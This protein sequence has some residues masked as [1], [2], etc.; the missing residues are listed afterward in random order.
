MIA[1]HY[2]RYKR[3]N[4]LMDYDDLIIYLRELLSKEP[5]I[6]KMISKRYRYIL[7]DEYQDTNSIQADIL[8]W[9]GSQSRNIMVVGD[10][11]Q[12]IYAFRGANYNN[13]FE[14][15]EIF[16]D[17]KIIKLEENYRSTQPILTFTNAIME[18][19]TKGYTKCLFTRKKDGVRPKIID[20]GT[21]PRQA[22]AVCRK[23]LELFDRG[24][25]LK[26]MAVLF[27]ASYHSFELE[28]ELTRNGIPYV[29]YGG[30][31]FME[32][33][34]I[35]DL[36]SHLRVVVNPRDQ[37]SWNRILR[38]VPGIGPVKARAIFEWL[39]KEGKLPGELADWPGM[40]KSEKGLKRLSSLLKRL[41]AP[42]ISPEK[43]VE[44][45]LKYYRPI[46]EERFDDYPKREKDLDQ[47]TIMAG[48]YK[49]LKNFI[50]DIVLE[51][52]TSSSEIVP[53]DKDEVL[54]LSTVHSAKGL[55]WRV[56]FIIWA[57]DGYFP[58]SRAFKDDEDM[59]EERRLMYVATT[60]AKELL[61]I[62][63]PGNEVAGRFYE[64]SFYPSNG[65][66]SF[67]RGISS[68]IVDYVRYGKG[69]HRDHDD[70]E[71][72]EE[73]NYEKSPELPL[74]P[75]DRVRHPAFGSGVISRVYNDDK[76]EVFFRDVGA[77]LLHL[78]YT[79][80]ERY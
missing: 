33:A 62:Y 39:K 12:A 19:A 56:V 74:S 52:P 17:T 48:R 28:K 70:Y 68:D 57:V 32:L 75:G 7:V 27:R 36:V 46:L 45:S 66:C 65:L 26:E 80:L 1:S 16:P 63:Y 44:L 21:E 22:M 47:L 6:R 60:R 3:E 8:K 43:A 64:E 30:F 24:I 38:L 69:F 76:V 55:E 41:Q 51:P 34:H 58:S 18:R 20:A 59:E 40:R 77:K 11:S 61:F 71:E 25:R 29:K 4:H 9:L 72:V 42:G 31:K 14:F 79:T 67:I 13:M 54:T 10:D 5:E 2:S 73:V 53:P 15:P 37:F 35:K 78:K 23:I 49:L 50:D